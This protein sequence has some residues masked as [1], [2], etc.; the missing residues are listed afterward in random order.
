MGGTHMQQQDM[1]PLR[2]KRLYL[3]RVN[4]SDKH[5]MYPVITKDKGAN[6][7]FFRRQ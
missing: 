1:K 2:G 3:E 7:L 5:N 4:N 6:E